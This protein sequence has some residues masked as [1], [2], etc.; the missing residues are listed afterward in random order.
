MSSNSPE[1]LYVYVI[2]ALVCS[3]STSFLVNL[4]DCIT[5]YVYKVLLP[6][7]IDLKPLVDR[8]APTS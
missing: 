7:L 6:Y 2:D 5:A 4:V 3:V 8:S 1:L